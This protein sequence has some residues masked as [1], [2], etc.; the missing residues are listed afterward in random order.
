[1][2]Q[3][4]GIPMPDVTLFQAPGEFGLF[5]QIAG[6]TTFGIFNDGNTNYV[7]GPGRVTPTPLI[8]RAQAGG[9]DAPV[10]PASNL[11]A[12]LGAALGSS[13]GVMLGGS[14]P[15]AQIA[16]RYWSVAN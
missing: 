6:L 1:M 14:N 7:R 11:G 3:A 4:F 8:E 13:V 15:L 10:L 2:A 9:M 16:W 5:G 12:Q